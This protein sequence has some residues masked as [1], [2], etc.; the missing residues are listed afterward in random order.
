MIIDFVDVDSRALP[1]GDPMTARVL[2]LAVIF[3]IG[4][5][6]AVLFKRSL[7]SLYT[8]FFG[9]ASAAVWIGNPPTTVRLIAA[10]GFFL[11]GVVALVFY[12]RRR[13]RN[14]PDT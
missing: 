8:W 4:W 6:E 9:L 11:S 5:A 14:S 3:L 10:W 1:H 2:L 12:R 13:P 7:L